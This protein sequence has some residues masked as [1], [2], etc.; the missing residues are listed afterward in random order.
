M[1]TSLIFCGHCGAQNPKSENFCFSCGYELTTST[2]AAPVPS[3]L[4]GQLPA[5]TLIK[6]RYRV[7]QTLGLGGMGAV[8]LAQDTQLGDRLVAVKEMGQSSLSGQQTQEAVENFQRETHILASLQH[9][10]LP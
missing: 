4:T 7:L 1:A 8:Y 9:P 2:A 10:N 3:T 5:H 6:Q